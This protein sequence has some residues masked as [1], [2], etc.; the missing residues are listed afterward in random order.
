M[1]LYNMRGEVI[2]D[3]IADFTASEHSCSSVASHGECILVNDDDFVYDVCYR[4]TQ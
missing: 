2:D 4:I 1:S 3:R